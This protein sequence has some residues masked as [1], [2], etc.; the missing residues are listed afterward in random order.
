[1]LRYKYIEIRQKWVPTHPGYRISFLER[2]KQNILSRI[3]N[4][5]EKLPK[6]TTALNFLL[7]K[8]I[9][10]KI[11]KY[12]NL[13]QI[14]EWRPERHHFCDTC[15]SWSNSGDKLFLNQKASV[16]ICS[17]RVC[18]VTT[19]HLSKFTYIIYTYYVYYIYIYIYYYIY[20]I[21]IK[22]YIYKL[23][24]LYIYI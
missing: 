19:V 13:P 3:D 24:I 21:Y 14:A 17:W 5:R 20:V 6:D 1:M 2:S 11:K 23:Y 16:T 8:T 18:Y 7:T 15:C 12:F 10:K 4:N 22:F 9:T